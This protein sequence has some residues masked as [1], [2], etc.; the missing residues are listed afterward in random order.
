MG[1]GCVKKKRADERR[2]SDGSSD[3]CSSD[4][5]SV[6]A[7]SG[8]FAP[9]ARS[10]IALNDDPDLYEIVAAPGRLVAAAGLGSDERAERHAQV[11]PAFLRLNGGSELAGERVDDEEI[12]AGAAH[13][14]PD[15]RKFARI[16][17]T[18]RTAAQGHENAALGPV[19]ERQSRKSVAS[20]NSVSV[21]VDHGGRRTIKKKKT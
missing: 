8:V 20:G 1:G 5:A 15:A 12:A 21:R 10:G 16:D 2:R 6:E 19:L 9:S 11:G 14:E 3:G 17:R 7:E 13:F 18:H 4:R